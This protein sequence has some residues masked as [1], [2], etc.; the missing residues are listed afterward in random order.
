MASYIVPA[1]ATAGAA[2]VPAIVPDT[3]ATTATASA[4]LAAAEE[5][6]LDVAALVSLVAPALEGLVDANDA[7]GTETA[8]ALAAPPPTVAYPPRY[9]GRQRRRSVWEARKLAATAAVDADAMDAWCNRSSVSIMV[10][11][12]GDEW[13]STSTVSWGGASDMEGDE[14]EEE[15]DLEGFDTEADNAAWRVV[16]AHFYTSVRYEVD[17]P[18]YVR[19]LATY[20]PLGRGVALTASVLIRRAGEAHPSLAVSGWSVVRLLLTALVIAFKVVDDAGGPG[21]EVACGLGGGGGGRPRR[22]APTAS[23]A[24][25]AVGCGAPSPPPL[26]VLGGVARVGC[27]AASE[28]VA[29]EAVLLRVLNWR[30]SVTAAELAAEERRLYALGRSRQ[31][32]GVAVP[33]WYVARRG[34]AAVGM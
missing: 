17:L 22:S 28:L 30:V 21:W 14:V 34:E 12:S 10:T 26:G 8:A 11:D 27:V 31:E 15:E 25:A 2:A 33:L 19:R 23:A 4:A 1:A 5:D 32:V 3:A 7:V 18:Y 20:L 9:Y 13:M 6:D 16:A 29:A 24:A